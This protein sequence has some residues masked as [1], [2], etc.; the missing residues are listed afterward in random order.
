MK[1]KVKVEVK[2]EVEVKFKVKAKVKVK[3][4][5]EVLPPSSPGS[6]SRC[7]VPISY[8]RECTVLMHSSRYSPVSIN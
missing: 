4:N 1:V 3:L 7:I 6:I 5:I 2:V 8:Y